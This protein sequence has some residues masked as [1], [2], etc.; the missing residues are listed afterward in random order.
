MGYTA[1][2]DT[3][4][5]LPVGDLV[6]HYIF[7]SRLIEAVLPMSGDIVAD[8]QL[9]CRRAQFTPHFPDPHGNRDDYDRVPDVRFDQRHPY[10]REHVQNVEEL[11][12]LLEGIPDKIADLI[13]YQLQETSAVRIDFTKWLGQS[14][15]R[16]ATS[17]PTILH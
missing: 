5:E 3:A 16:R 9:S 13:A 8:F 7:F 17:D 4:K 10:L 1:N 14:S 2:L 11:H 15:R 6:L 12:L